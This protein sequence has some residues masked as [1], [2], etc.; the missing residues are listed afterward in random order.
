[1]NCRRGVHTLRADAIGVSL[2]LFGLSDGPK[3]EYQRNP[4]YASSSN[5]SGLSCVLAYWTGFGILGS[6]V[7][8]LTLGTKQNHARI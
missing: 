5:Q 8:Y 1:M 3:I 6:F 2:S 4:L 7:V